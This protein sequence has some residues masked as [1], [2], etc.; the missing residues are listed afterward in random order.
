MKSMFV[1]RSSVAWPTASRDGRLPS[2]KFGPS[3]GSSSES[4]FDRCREQL[5]GIY[6]YIARDSPH[7]AKRVIDQIVR[8]SS[9]TAIMPRAAAIVPEFSR[10]DVREVFAYRYRIIYRI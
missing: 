6:T 5:D 3:T 9:N 8:K 7:Y 2:S 1:R 10:P 4:P